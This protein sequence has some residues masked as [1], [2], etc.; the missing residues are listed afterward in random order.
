MAKRPQNNGLHAPMTIYEVHLGSWMRV[1][2]EGNRSLTYRELADQ[3]PEYVQSMG[4]THVEFMPIMEHPFYGSWGYQITGYFAPTSRYGT[5]QDLMTLVDRLH[6]RGI[7]VILDWVPSHFPPTTTAWR[8]STARTCT[9]TPTRARASTRNGTACIFNYGRNEVR[10]FLISNALFWLEKYHVDGLRVD[11]VASMLY[12]DYSR[13]EGEWIPNA[14][15]GRENLDAISFLRRMNEEVSTRGIRT[16]RRSRR[17]PPPGRWSRGRPTSAG[18]ASASSGTWAGC[19]T[20]S[21]TCPRTRSTGSIHHNDLTFRHAL[22]LQR[23][24]R[25]AALARRSRAR[26]RLAARQDARRRLAEIRQPPRALRLHVRAAGQ[27]AALHGR[28]VRPV[29]ASGTT[30]RAWTGTCSST[31]PHQGMRTGCAT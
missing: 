27:E 9:S 3:L 26:Q 17:N 19:T 24:L 10:S 28:R 15:G 4:F 31:P 7:G 6:Q 18:S 22:R 25:P 12:L 8:T 11:A 29:A 13:E 30:T 5:P 1:P 23:E 2:E 21:A 14:H 16:R 20:R